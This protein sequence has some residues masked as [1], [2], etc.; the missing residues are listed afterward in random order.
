MS[1][2]L[3]TSRESERPPHYDEGV[4][5]TKILELGVRVHH[6][7][8]GEGRPVFV[9]VH[10]LGGSH[11]NWAPIVGALARRGRVLVP[12]LAGFG[13]TAPGPEGSTVDANLALLTRFI[14]AAAVDGPV[15]L[16]GNSMGGYLAMRLAATRPDLVFGLVLVDPAAPISLGLDLDPRVVAMFAGFA[17]PGLATWLMRRRAAASGPEAA[18]RDM[19]RLCTVDLARV[20]PEVLDAH[21]ELARARV[22]MPWVA[23]A[24]LEAAR[25]LLVALARRPTY[26]ALVDAVRAPTL[27][28]HGA[29][30]RLVPVQ[31]A[32]H[33][34]ARRPDWQ[35]E[36]HA[37]LGHVPQLESPGWFLGVVEPWL[38]RLPA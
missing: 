12:D 36:E 19:L 13:R 11:L 37:D 3:D 14:E 1:S 21:V 4:T 23:E 9:L 18:V 8:E 17:V 29:R 15:I 32:R 2:R 25:S 26:H 7:D 31:A 5:S 30:D 20:D 33:L 24:F 22:A 10:G 28:V 27:L 38:D 6:L 16:A 35:Y 34:A